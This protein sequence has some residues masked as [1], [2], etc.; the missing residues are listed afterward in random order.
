M[1]TARD[2]AQN[3]T[4][5]STSDMAYALLR[6]AL[7]L[8]GRGP[9]DLSADESAQV[10]RQAER[11]YRIEQRV[12]SSPEAARVV[13][14]DNEVEAAV[15][16]IAA[17]YPDQESF[18]AATG[19]H[20]VSLRSLKAALRRQLRVEATLERVG[21]RAPKVSDADVQLYYQLHPERFTRPPLR[22]A[23]HILI[24][25]N[26]DFPENTRERALERIETLLRMIDGGEDFEALARQHSECPTAL[27]GGRL[28]EVPKGKLYSEIDGVLF[29]LAEGE[30]SGPVESPIGFH[31]LY[32]EKVHEAGTVAF[33][34]VRSQ[35]RERLQAQMAV[36]HQREWL[37][38]LG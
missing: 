34:A 24:T 33:D 23:R 30:V 7:N 38:A 11:E 29:E 20:G 36:R 3:T 4:P 12:L 5:G 14:R 37:K 21:S 9:A 31:I 27:E 10:R 16:E 28:G 22:S 32:C 18:L 26:P 1:N 6:A 17:R 8:Y 25:V 13:V 2:T 19:A 35:V 15:R